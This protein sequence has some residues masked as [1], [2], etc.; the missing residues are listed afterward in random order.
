MQVKQG[1]NGEGGDDTE[2]DDNTENS[3][4]S[5]FESQY[6]YWKMP[7][8]KNEVQVQDMQQKHIW[9]GRIEKFNSGCPGLS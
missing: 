6:Q 8:D 4:D 7:V 3:M 9:K 2:N 5:I 1:D